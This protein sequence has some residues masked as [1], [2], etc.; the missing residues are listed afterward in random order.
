MNVIKETING[1]TKLQVKKEI[2]SLVYKKQWL[3]WSH[4]TWILGMKRCVYLEE[5][6]SGQ[7]KKKDKKFIMSDM[8][9]SRDISMCLSWVNII[10]KTST[11]FFRDL[12]SG[13]QGG[14]LT[15]FLRTIKGTS[16]REELIKV[17]YFLIIKQRE[18]WRVMDLWYLEWKEWLSSRQK[19]H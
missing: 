10:L 9:G 5:Q 2:K 14:W 19:G 7:G 12:I 17:I 6:F 15:W 4:A 1:T 18:F 11:F 8:A 16:E 3:N 13:E